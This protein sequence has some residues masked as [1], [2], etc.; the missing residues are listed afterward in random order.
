MEQRLLNEIIRIVGTHRD[1]EGDYCDTGDDM[2]WSCRS[3]CTDL[4]IERLAAASRKGE[5]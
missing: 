2:D 1:G 5:I 3:K 4:A